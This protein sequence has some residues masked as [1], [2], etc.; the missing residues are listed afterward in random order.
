MAHKFWLAQSDT[1][2]EAGKW[3]SQIKSQEF[4]QEVLKL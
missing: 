4:Q 2:E 1:R 3:L